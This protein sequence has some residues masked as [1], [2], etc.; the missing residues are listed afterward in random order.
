MLLQQIPV[1]PQPRYLQQKH[2]QQ[3]IL[4][5]GATRLVRGS[6]QL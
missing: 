4:Q 6:K 3:K 2:E 5:V 1:L